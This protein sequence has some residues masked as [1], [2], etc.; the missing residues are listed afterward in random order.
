MKNIFISRPTTI[1]DDFESSYTFFHNFLI[2]QGYTLKRLGGG[3]Y[4]K[5][6]PLKAVINLIHECCGTIILG[7]P[8]YEF[9]HKAARSKLYFIHLPLHIIFPHLTLKQ[10]YFHFFRFSLG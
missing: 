9:I 10:F 6:A 1:N 8:Q 5:A 4:S 2:D 3:T 7:Y